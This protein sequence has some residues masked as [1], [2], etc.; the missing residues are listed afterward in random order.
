MKKVVKSILAFE[1]LFGL[2]LLHSCSTP[3]SSQ[4]SNLPKSQGKLARI[5]FIT[6]SKGCQCT[7]TRCI[8]AEKI[9]QRVLKNYPNAPK[10]EKVDYAVEQTKAI[11]FVK[12]YSAMMLPILYLTDSKENLLW[13]KDGDFN[14][15]EL[16]DVL[17]KL[18]TK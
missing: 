11:Y 16:V 10:V 5:I 9:L 13:K 12:K 1:V 15:A 8:E 6:T 4:E 3:S 2:F 18:G 7:L 14:E 17:N